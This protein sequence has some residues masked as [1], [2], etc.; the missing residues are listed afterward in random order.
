[1][2]P[3]TLARVQLL[4]AALL[5]S[6]GGAAI[7]ATSLTGWQVASLRSA[8]A[9]P[10]V[11]LMVPAARRRWN[12]RTFLVGIP[13]AATM[14]LFV[15][16]TKLTTSANAIFLQSTAPLYVL[17]LSPWL[18]RERVRAADLGFMAA[19]AAGLA[20]FF[21]GVEQPQATAPNPALGNV[22]GV[23]SGV[24][25][26]LTVMGLRWLG[27]RGGGNGEVL[28]TVVA[29]NAIACLVI[30]PLALPVSGTGW[31]DWL[32]IS[33]LGV[34]QVGLA[35]VCL[36]AG[37]R[38]VPALEASTLLLAE[39]ALNPIWVWLAH[40]EVPGHWGLV[41]GAV[42]LVA[43]AVRTWSSARAPGNVEAAPPATEIPSATET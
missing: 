27:G 2:S 11:L 15:T 8:I 39:P 41:G 24:A 32:A 9:V 31:A 29:G 20:L 36:T 6:T 21:V 12:W 23:L 13:Y 14:I 33:Y 18:L 5:F 25:W 1:M 38:R 43:T 30:L 17:L 35:Y 19:V 26:A 3:R 37:L 4:A 40:G 7:K 42:I 22:L 10:A 16:S 34:V 28:S